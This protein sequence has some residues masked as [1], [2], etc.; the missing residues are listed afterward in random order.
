M[1]K[2]INGWVVEVRTDENG[3]TSTHL[4]RGKGAMPSEIRTIIEERF[5]GK[6]K[7]LNQEKPA[8]HKAKR[9]KSKY[10][11]PMQKMQKEEGNDGRP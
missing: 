3:N 7:H 8:F 5:E 4:K 2:E 6:G 9:N 11:N 10:E 1:K